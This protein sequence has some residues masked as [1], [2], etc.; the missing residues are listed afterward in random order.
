MGS[1]L[2]FLRRLLAFSGPGYLIA[3]GYMDPGNWATDIAGGAQFGYTLLSVIALSSAI[4]M[5]LQHLALKVGIVTGKDLAELCREYPRPVRIGLW[6]AAEGMIIACDIAEVIGSAIAL[7]LLFGVPLP[8]GVVLTG[9]DVFLLLFLQHKGYRYLEGF[10]IVL[11]ATIFACFAIEVFFA[12]PVW[13]DVLKGF[14]PTLQIVTEPSMLYLALGI[15]GATVMP[16][17]LFLHSAVVRTRSGLEGVYTKRE[18]LRFATLDSSIA[19][20]FAFC[21]NAAIL[22]V[23]AATFHVAGLFSVSELSDAYHLLSP[24][25]G[26]ASAS[27]IFAIALLASGQNST[28][29]GTMAGQIIMEGFLNWRIAPW[30]RRLITRAC[31]IVPALAVAIY[32]GEQGVTSLLVL[33]QVVLSMQLP[34]AVVPLVLF[35]SQKRYMGAYVNSWFLASLG[36]VLAAV[37]ILLNMWLLIRYM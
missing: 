34:F 21:V 27:T 16:H 7:Q 35:T 19:L 17:N 1:V 12:H 30:V 28:L 33:S 4:A 11:V 2:T 8:Y 24:V 25:V 23:S 32:A 9:L 10:V 14:V 15:I 22:I 26:A 36:A 20:L 18:A 6:L 5:V 29:T 31:A 13:G 3:V 37:L